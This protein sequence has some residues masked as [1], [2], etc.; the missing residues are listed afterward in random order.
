MPEA[1]QNVAAVRTLHPMFASD[2]ERIFVYGNLR[3]GQPCH[4]W[5]AGA[6]LLGTYRTEPHFTMRDLGAFAGVTCGGETAIVG[7]VYAVGRELLRAIDGY[8]CCPQLFQRLRLNTPWGWAWIY[9]LPA[10]AADAAPVVPH[11]DWV[12]WQA[13]RMPDCRDEHLLT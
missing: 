1:T 7:E 2:T 9:L 6:H 13:R 10:H 5:L 3:R 11:G 4:H 8:E 12:V